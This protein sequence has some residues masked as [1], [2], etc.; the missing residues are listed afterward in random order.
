MATESQ[1]RGWL[2]RSNDLGCRDFTCRAFRFVRARVRRGAQ[3]AILLADEPRV[4][5][6]WCR[7]WEAPHYARLLEWRAGGFRPQVFYDL[8]AH[9]G[10][11]SEMCYSVFAPET[12]VLFE[13]QRD[14]ETEI[15]SRSARAG[16]QWKLMPVALGDQ[17]GQATLHVNRQ[18]AASSMLTPDSAAP[19][20]YWG[21]DEAR[22]ESVKVATLD[23]LVASCNLPAPDL[24]KMDVQGF[25]AKILAGGEQTIRKAARL[26]IEVSL[27]PIY[28]GQAL[29]PEVLAKLT[30]W[31]FVVEDI[32]E[33]LR[34]W[35]SGG[36]W[37]VDLWLI[38]TARIT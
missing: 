18:S 27:R 7:G 31:G 13:P 1:R 28:D 26:V 11:W 5:R 33:A 16:A 30:Q 25:E 15:L 9:R 2:E 6:A 29:L 36:L 34:R 10:I 19:S 17:D 12:C 21:G 24:I 3:W 32:N 37:Q 14:R 35:P 4:V 22:R 23:G 20:E 8:G 38:N